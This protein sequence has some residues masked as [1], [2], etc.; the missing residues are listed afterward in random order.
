MYMSFWLEHD[1]TISSLHTRCFIV[2][3]QWWLVKTEKAQC[4]GSL[5]FPPPAFWEWKTVSTLHHTI[6]LSLH[7]HIYLHL[8]CTRNNRWV[9]IP[10]NFVVFPYYTFY[11]YSPSLRWVRFD[12]IPCKF[13]TLHSGFVLRRILLFKLP[14][15]RKWVVNE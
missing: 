3:G 11:V 7:I 6:T 13:N 12:T 9:K 1:V 15:D 14:F 8:A 10:T 5:L 2:T 4:C